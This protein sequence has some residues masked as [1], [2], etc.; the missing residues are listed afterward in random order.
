MNY[1]D[2]VFLIYCYDVHMCRFVW[3]VAKC[4][5]DFS[6]K[7]KEGYISAGMEVNR[8]HGC[9][10]HTYIHAYIVY[11]CT[12]YICTYVCR[13]HLRLHFIPKELVKT[14]DMRSVSTFIYVHCLYIYIHK[15]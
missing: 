7:P 9:L 14:S 10:C 11:S 1:R 5:Q 2:H 6:I 4:A 3:D 15:H 12:V 8:A 13:C